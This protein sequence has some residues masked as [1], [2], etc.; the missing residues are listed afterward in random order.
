MINPPEGDTNGNISM[1]ELM[2]VI[3]VF[4]QGLMASFSKLKGSENPPNGPRI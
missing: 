2:P 4:A 3:A 1:T